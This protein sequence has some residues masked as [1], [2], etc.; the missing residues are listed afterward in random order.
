[1]TDRPD[2]RPAGAVGVGALLARSRFEV[3]PLPSAEA[4]AAHLPTG[5]TVT[6]TCSPRRGVDATVALAERLAAGGLH[7]V[8]H[9]AARG[10]RDR[11]HLRDVVRRLGDAGIDEAFVIGGD[12]GE[13]VGP[14]ESALDLLEALDVLGRPLA[15]IGVAGYPERHPFIG[16]ETLFRALADKRPLASYVVTQICFDPAA[17]VRWWGELRDRGIDLPVYVGMP[18]AVTRRKLLEIALRIGVGDSI[19]YL[20]KHGGLVARLMRRGSFRPDAFVA[21]LSSSLAEP[22]HPVAGF[23]INTFNQV[24]TTERW[25]QRAMATYGWSGIPRGEAGA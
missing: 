10:V 3:V 5:T 23:H 18:G 17:V 12:P 16:R 11:E 8:P 25:R 14:F 9:V 4:Q 7:A 20:S 15:R 21:G 19:R 1:V 22:G 2:R 6:V 24:R 13:P